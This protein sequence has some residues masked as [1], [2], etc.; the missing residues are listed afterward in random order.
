MLIDSALGFRIEKIEKVEKDRD[1]RAAICK[2]KMVAL[3]LLGIRTS[4]NLA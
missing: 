4:P 3:H 1:Y 2:Q